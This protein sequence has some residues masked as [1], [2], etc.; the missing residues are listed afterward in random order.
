[1][2]CARPASPLE[3]EAERLQRLIRESEGRTREARDPNGLPHE[4]WRQ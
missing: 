4:I 1:V 2:I 3:S